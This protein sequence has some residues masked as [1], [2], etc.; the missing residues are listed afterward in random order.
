MN[1]GFKLYF[2]ARRD[3]PKREGELLRTN[4]QNLFALCPF[5]RSAPAETLIIDV[6][7]VKTIIQPAY[8]R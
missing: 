8:S 5:S 1:R 3:S 4:I 2:L 7:N 6:K